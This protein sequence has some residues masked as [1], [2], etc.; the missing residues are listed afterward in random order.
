MNTI[1]DIITITTTILWILSLLI[2]IICSI[3]DTSS[4]YTSYNR[5]EEFVPIL[6]AILI[7]ILLYTK[8]SIRISS[9]TLPFIY[10]T[11][12]NTYNQNI[13]LNVNSKSYIHYLLPFKW[14][15][16][17][18]FI[19]LAFT[20]SIHS[21]QK[22]LF[23][24]SFN[25]RNTNILMTENYGSFEYECI[26]VS[27]SQNAEIR[28]ISLSSMGAP[29]ISFGWFNELL[30]Y[31]YGINQNKN[32]SICGY[33]RGGFGFTETKQYRDKTIES[34]VKHLIEISDVLFGKN[35]TFHLMGH[36]RSGLILLQAKM[37]YN[38]RI[39][40]IVIFDGVSN[41][42]KLQ[43]FIN[44]AT[45][46]EFSSNYYQYTIASI[47]M[48]IMTFELSINTI[49]MSTGVSSKEKLYKS[50]LMAKYYGFRNYFY[51]SI[52]WEGMDMKKGWENTVKMYHHGS[53]E[54]VFDPVLNIECDEEYNQLIMYS[55]I[56]NTLYVKAA[57]SPCVFDKDIANLIFYY[58]DTGL[59]VFYDS[60][61]L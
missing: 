18:I 48:P 47:A 59:K 16:F 41:A 26:G 44:N 36:S 14:F 61:F 22:S 49:A 15:L 8:L 50:Q 46:R 55:Q 33:N 20:L 6:P 40:S 37:I 11:N 56:N 39:D 32:V 52:V 5:W 42:N 58:N 3:S 38:D 2:A 10:N 27:P 34:D 13:L 57:H 53:E 28:I 31:E 60:L 30:Y 19:C 24:N 9:N 12:Y 43:N 35:K 51:Q 54:Y 4:K 7:Q 21:I 29:Y 1:D 17:I 25:E 45:K 23:I